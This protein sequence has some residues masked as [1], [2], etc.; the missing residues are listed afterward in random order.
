[1]ENKITLDL[2]TLKYIDFIFKLH[3]DNSCNTKGYHNLR[4]LIKEEE[5]K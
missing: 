5:K 3:S 4:K 1:M 2:K